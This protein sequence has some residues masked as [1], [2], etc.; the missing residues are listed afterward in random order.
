MKDY[1]AEAM[2]EYDGIP[3]GKREKVWDWSTQSYR[4]M[5]M[6][7]KRTVTPAD[8]DR[9]SSAMEKENAMDTPDKPG[10]RGSA[11]S[12][13][14]R[15]AEIEICIREMG[16]LSKRA[17]SEYTGYTISQIT[18]TIRSY[19]TRFYVAGY[20]SID[21]NRGGTRAVYDLRENTEQ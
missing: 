11:A 2:R 9:F 14:H 15:F 10:V 16:P 6:V 18:D 17:V 7:T 4:T 3:V 13:K 12:T 20:E 21:G 1:Y 19:D 8:P 5:R